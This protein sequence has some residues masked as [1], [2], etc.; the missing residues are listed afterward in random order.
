MRLRAVVARSTSPR[1]GLVCAVFTL[2][3]LRIASGQ[4]CSLSRFNHFTSTTCSQA[5]SLL[6]PP[7]PSFA[8]SWLEADLGGTFHD[9]DTETSNP[10][11][12]RAVTSPAQCAAACCGNPACEAFEIPSDNTFCWLW[13]HPHANRVENHCYSSSQNLGPAE[14]NAFGHGRHDTYVR[15]SPTSFGAITAI[16]DHTYSTTIILF[17]R[18]R[19]VNLPELC[20]V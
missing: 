14:E 3:S 13:L 7:L 8:P 15:V 9:Y 1:S 18:L 17:W 16:H 6:Q 2:H 10:N 12:P 20:C 5:S 19:G 4:A 11:Y